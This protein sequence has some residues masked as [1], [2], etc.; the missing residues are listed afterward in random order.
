MTGVYGMPKDP[1][2]RAA[3]DALSAAL[4][5]GCMVLPD[6]VQPGD[7]PRW[8]RGGVKA[9]GADARRLLLFWG[10]APIN[11]GNVA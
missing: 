7:R 4:W 6:S 10:G 3:D 8:A 9:A 5:I 2:A 1:G 11:T